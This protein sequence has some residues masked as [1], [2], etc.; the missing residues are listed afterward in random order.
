MKKGNLAR[1]RPYD[2][3]DFEVVEQFYNGFKSKEINYTSA[4]KSI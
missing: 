1:K 4:I 3:L 2:E